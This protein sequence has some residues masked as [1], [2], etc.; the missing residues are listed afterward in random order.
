MNECAAQARHENRRA[1]AAVFLYPG[2]R[3]VTA[4]PLQSAACLVT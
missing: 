3:G 1:I 2:L 4:L